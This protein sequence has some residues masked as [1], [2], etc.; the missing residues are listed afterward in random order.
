MK[1][2]ESDGRRNRA[3]AAAS[4]GA[5]AVVLVLQLLVPPI[6]GLANEGDFERVMG[7]AGLRYLTDHRDEKFYNYV[8][9]RFEVAAPGWYRSGYLTSETL[10]AAVARASSRVFF[11]GERFD[12][13]LLGAV[14][15]LLLLIALWIL[16][17]SCRDL[18]VPAQW[19]VAIL[20]VLFFTDV[21]YA[22]AFNSF[23]AQAASLLF[24]LLTVAIASAGVRRGG[25]TGSLL[26]G[27]FLVAALFVCSKPQESIQGPWLA[28]WGMQLGRVGLRRWWRKAAF[29]LAVAL[30]G[31]SLWCYRSVPREGVRYVG[32]FHNVFRELLPHSP[33]PAGDLKELGLDPDLREYSGMHAYMA[34]A[35]I[36]DPG[37]QARFFSRFGYR[38]LLGFYLRHPGRLGDR[39]RRAAPGAFRLRPSYLGN[40]DRA[41][42]FPPKTKTTHFALWSDARARLGARA[43]LWLAVFFGANVI[44]LSA[45]WRRAS[46]RGRLYLS[47]LAFLLLMS[48]TEFLVCALADC[49][50]DVGRHL[51]VFDA[52]CD[53]IVIADCGWLAQ[54]IA[55]RLLRRRAVAVLPPSAV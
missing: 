12:I 6:V 42:G 8:V 16:V 28:A 39:L 53:L 44:A 47:A 33:D 24:L 5:A 50:D 19:I 36:R 41:A 20:L 32:L 14:H 26:V 54:A 17:R 21:G 15:A 10:L 34:N 31:F 51:Y 29:W 4:A 7:Y 27:Y 11:P 46:S 35:P 3:L 49:L 18:A 40:Y 37:F 52:L 9:T 30:C 13:R 48:G 45:A 22:A 25:F 43:V 38:K 55:S 2:P 23:Y 1:R